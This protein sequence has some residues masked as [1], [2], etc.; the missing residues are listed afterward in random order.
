MNQARIPVF[1][2][3]SKASWSREGREWACPKLTHLTV[4][5]KLIENLGENCHKVWPTNSDRKGDMCLHMCFATLR[6]TVTDHTVSTFLVIFTNPKKKK[7]ELE[8]DSKKG[9]SWD[10][11]RISW[12]KN[13]KLYCGLTLSLIAI[14]W[15][16]SCSPVI[17]FL[18]SWWFPTNSKH[19]HFPAKQIS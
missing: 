12:K 19:S 1:W 16:I 11:N 18:S 14:T 13:E 2:F 17:W 6:C 5:E 15:N 9:S 3:H 8:L 10:E 4:V 7:K